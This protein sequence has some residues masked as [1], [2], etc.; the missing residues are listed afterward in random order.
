LKVLSLGMNEFLHSESEIYQYAYSAVRQAPIPIEH[1]QMQ[2]INVR[3]D[4]IDK[5]VNYT[6]TFQPMFNGEANRA[7]TGW[8]YVSTEMHYFNAK[9]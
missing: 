7:F 9:E 1:W 3:Y 8:E 5:Q 4:M 2:R 6:V